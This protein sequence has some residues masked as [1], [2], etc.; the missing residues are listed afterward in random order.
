[1]KR[2]IR[3]IVSILLL[4]FVFSFNCLAIQDTESLES[5]AEDAIANKASVAK[6][7]FVFVI[8]STGSMGS[9]IQSVRTNLSS[10]SKYLIEKNIDVRF[11]VIDYKDIFEDGYNT[12]VIHN[13][14]GGIWTKEV[15]TLDSCLNRLNVDGGGDGPETP[16][17]A[18]RK[19][20]TKTYNDSFRADATRFAFLLTDATSKEGS[21]LYSLAKMGNALNTNS[22]H[23]SVVSKADYSSH[24][25]PLW[26]KTGGIFID[27][28]SSNFYQLMLEVADWIIEQSKITMSLSTTKGGK[29][30]SSLIYNSGYFWPSEKSNSNKFWLNVTAMDLG[31]KSVTEKITLPAG[32]SFDEKKEKNAKSIKIKGNGAKSVTVSY[33]VYSY[34]RNQKVNSIQIKAKDKIEHLHSLSVKTLVPEITMT[35]SA[36]KNGA[37]LK[38]LYSSNGF[39]RA[40]ADTTVNAVWLNITANNVAAPSMTVSFTLPKGLS[41]SENKTLSTTKIYIGGTGT[42]TLK[43]SFHLY[44][45]EIIDDIPE[46][47]V[48]K[49]KI[50]FA[51]DKI[52]EIENSLTLEVERVASV[53]MS[54]WDSRKGNTVTGK[55]IKSL[56]YCDGNLL[57]STVKED[58]IFYLNVQMAGIKEGEVITITLPEG[59]CFVGDQYSSD[60]RIKTINYKGVKVTGEKK[61]LPVYSV[62]KK[63][64]VKEVKIKAEFG[65]KTMF[66]KIF[67]RRKRPVI[68]I[69]KDKNI[70][71]AAGGYERTCNV[72]LGSI[73]GNTVPRTYNQSLAEFGAMMSFSVYNQSKIESS[74]HNLGFHS[75]EYKKIGGTEESS[76]CCFGVKTITGSDGKITNLA[77]IVVRGTI[78]TK[79]WIGNFIV[80]YGS[81]PKSF[82]KS[83]R[84]VIKAFDKYITEKKLTP[85]DTAIYVCGHSRGAAAANITAHELLGKSFNYRGVTGYTF[86]TPNTTKLLFGDKENI[87]NFKYFYDVVGY[88]PQGYVNYGHTYVFG[89]SD[90]IANGVKNTYEQ[91]TKQPYK[92]AKHPYIIPLIITATGMANGHITNLSWLAGHIQAM[93]VDKGIGADNTHSGEMYISWVVNQGT[94]NTI[95]YEKA[96]VKQMAKVVKS[97][98][99][100]ICETI[101]RTAPIPGPVRLFLDAFATMLSTTNKI[102]IVAV[103]CPVDVTLRDKNDKAS[104]VVKNHVLKS[105]DTT[106]ALAI[107][108]GETDFFVYPANK[109]YYLDISGNAKGEMTVGL[110]SFDKGL[111]LKDSTV[112]PNIPVTKKESFI[113]KPDYSDADKSSLTSETGE[114]YTAGLPINLMLPGSMTKLPNNAFSGNKALVGRVIVPEGISEIGSKVF[115]GTRITEVLLP[116]SVKKIAKDAFAGMPKDA[117][118][119]CYKGSFA[120]NWLKKKALK[121]DYR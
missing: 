117:K 59:L 85:K 118:F 73:Y 12:T 8:D 61:V 107:S 18:L 4:S 64:S 82:K 31:K 37:A 81:Q 78:G 65:E 9:Y 29:G 96:V 23:T 108:E 60:N 53:E 103:D 54:L 71:K 2:F 120:E 102:E 51:S 17:D 27:I 56:D 28:D 67:V 106:E 34:L 94:A 35:V 91:F 36:G 26:N 19:L 111:K 66:N 104:I 89:A 98:S 44:S 7:D 97:A 83:A 5:N 70:S 24:Y 92:L 76:D 10:F 21:G 116:K 48:I 40:T 105:L 20:I 33:P 49:S 100:V 14:G 22:I 109:G 38:K 6:A 90:Y 39:Y 87:Y 121:Y 77:A 58:N 30:L 95:S 113:F 25:S 55:E 15:S 42:P 13:L 69:D 46:S 119:Y 68:Y 1:M 112:F 110:A 3:T 84:N 79:E 93:L 45:K 52:V 63:Q 88:V 32:L 75:V 99:T 50:G 101:E 80:G 114:T 11:S 47:I 41:F 86:A 74:L 115:K 16:T 43:K 72:D 57:S 62:Y